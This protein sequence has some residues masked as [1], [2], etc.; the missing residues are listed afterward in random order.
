[1]KLPRPRFSLRLFLLFVSATSA[2]FYW[3]FVRPTVIAQRFVAAVEAKDFS[4]AESFCS[5]SNCEFLTPHIS[6]A[7]STEVAVK[8]LPRRW[9][10]IYHGRRLMSLRVV[11]G[12]PRPGTN[13]FVGCQANLVATASGL[14]PPKMYFVTFKR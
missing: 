1:M 14:Q 7:R 12:E 4:R 8:I 11:P 3:W 5:E 6:D 13:D 2:A 9:S 10:D